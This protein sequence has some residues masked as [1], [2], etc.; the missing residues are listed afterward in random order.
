[1][2]T[3]SPTARRVPDPTATT[4][5][6][7]RTTA[8]VALRAASSTSWVARTTAPPAAACPR[9]ARSSAVREGASIPRVGSSRS[10]TSAPPTATAATATRWRSP[11]ASDRG[12]RSARCDE[13]EGVE[14]VVDLA[15]VAAAEEPQ[16]LVQ[17]GPHGRSEQQGVRILGHVRDP[18]RAG[19][20][21][22]T[23]TRGAGR[24]PAGGSSFRHR[25]GRA[26]RRPHPRRA[27]TETS[28]QHRAATEVDRDPGR[29]DE[30]LAGF[31][32]T[33]AGRTGS[34]ARPAR[35]DRFRPVRSRG[36]G[37]RRR[38]RSAAVAPIRGGGRGG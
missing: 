28:S 8:R 22:P 23:G 31:R 19:R 1:M 7:P 21:C 26:A 14:P 4:S 36:H 6:S 12:W 13:R 29:V 15:V 16:G 24:A 17:L 38:G 9:S 34:V 37:A 35:H 27:D 5:P 32:R 18:A 3:A 11:P 33:G 20:R 10:R 30:D 2:R 25:C